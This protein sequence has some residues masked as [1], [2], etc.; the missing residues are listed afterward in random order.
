MIDGP[1]QP[2]AGAPELI[3]LESHAMGFTCAD[4]MAGRGPRA[5]PGEL[6]PEWLW[7][8]TDPGLVIPNDA[9]HLARVLQLQRHLREAWHQM[10]SERFDLI[11][12]PLLGLINDDILP[13]FTDVKVMRDAELLADDLAPLPDLV[14][15]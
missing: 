5:R 13:R 4:P 7:P 10:R 6:C 9:Q 11:Y 8:F 1:V 15:A 14:T 3:G 12:R 2:A